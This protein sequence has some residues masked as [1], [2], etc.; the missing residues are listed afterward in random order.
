[1]QQDTSRIQIRTNQLDI[2]A[3]NLSQESIQSI[4]DFVT[5]NQTKQMNH[6]SKANFQSLLVGILLAVILG[7]TVYTIQ[8]ISSS[9]TNNTQEITNVK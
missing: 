9:K 6:E 2:K 3:S 5:I 7:I 4:L 1:M 8:S